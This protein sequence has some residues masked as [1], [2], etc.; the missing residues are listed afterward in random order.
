[1]KIERLFHGG[2]SQKEIAETL[3]V[4]KGYVSQEMKKLDLSQ[5]PKKFAGGT[6]RDDEF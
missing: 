5:T 3:G 4:S 2:M 6:L 1:V